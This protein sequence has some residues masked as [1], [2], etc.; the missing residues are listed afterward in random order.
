VKYFKHAVKIDPSSIPA[1]YGLGKAI[2]QSTSD[3]VEDAIAHFES[4]VNRDKN[5]FKAL[6]QLGI[7]YLSNNQYDKAALNLNRALQINKAYLPALLQM[8]NC[9][10]DTNNYDRAQK[11]FNQ[12]L[13]HNSEEVQALIGLGNISY[14][15]D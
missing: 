11:Y 1:I 7:I 4:V 15:K 6:T 13:R 5:H 10:Y 12:A 2:Q 8:G 9:L 14:K 3:P